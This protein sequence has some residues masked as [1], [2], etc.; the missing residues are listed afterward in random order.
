MSKYTHNLCK[1]RYIF[2]YVKNTK[3]VYISKYLKN[4]F[5]IVLKLDTLINNQDI[6]KNS[7]IQK[8]IKIRYIL[9]S[10]FRRQNHE[11]LPV[12]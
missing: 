2:S 10:K 6:I 12:F 5:Q 1:N 11:N 4:I 8:T 7:D 9:T 3:I